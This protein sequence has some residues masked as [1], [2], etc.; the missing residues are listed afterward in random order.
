MEKNNETNIFSGKRIFFID[1]FVK[2]Q[3]NEK[4]KKK[5]QIENELSLPLSLFHSFSFHSFIR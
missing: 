1:I 3:T 2:K 4:R 5:Q